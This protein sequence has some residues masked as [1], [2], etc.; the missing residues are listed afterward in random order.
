MWDIILTDQR[1]RNRGLK[2]SAEA[3]VMGPG[4]KKGHAAGESM[5]QKR[6]A[7]R[8]RKLS[9]CRT[10]H[11]SLVTSTKLRLKQLW[12]EDLPNRW[13]ETAFSLLPYST[14]QTPGF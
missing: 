1:P 7:S 10:T 5:G 3:T 6:I 9:E 4:D 8:K 13:S 12:N 11:G 14:E 2:H